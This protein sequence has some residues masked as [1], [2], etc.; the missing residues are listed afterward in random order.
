ML[1]RSLPNVETVWGWNAD[2]IEQDA[3]G[4]RVA[5]SE[6]TGSGKRELKA[7]YVVG[8]DGGHSVVRDQIGISRSGSDY[9]Q[10][11]VLAVIRS[12]ELHEGLKRFPMRSTF[13]VMHPDLKGY[14]MFFG[15]IDVGEGFFFHAPVPNETT[16]ENYDF[17]GL[18]HRA[19]GFKFNC[20][21]EHVGFWDLRVAV[22]EQYQ[23]GR[24]FIAGDADR[25]STRL[26]SRH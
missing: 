19:A 23:V 13:N 24:A 26:N 17:L 12:K 15:R 10:K 9:D 16:V 3:E 8:C 1:F 18:L 6:R 20:E 11:M 21:F 4:V 14:W 5:I 22:A 25:K 7:Q 2:T